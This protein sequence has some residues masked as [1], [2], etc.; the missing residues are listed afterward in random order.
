MIENQDSNQE[1]YRS[2]FVIENKN[3]PDKCLMGTFCDWTTRLK[4]LEC[5]RIFIENEIK[6]E[7]KRYEIENGI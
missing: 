7:K 1:L 4:S 3:N 6:K 2:S 5:A